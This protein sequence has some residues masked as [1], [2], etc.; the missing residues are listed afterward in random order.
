MTLYNMV[1]NAWLEYEYHKKG[2]NTIIDSDIE[3]TINYP[4]YYKNVDSLHLVKAFKRITE[5]SVIELHV[6]RFKDYQWQCPP[7]SNKIPMFTYLPGHYIGYCHS[8]KDYWKRIT[9]TFDEREPSDTDTIRV[10]PIDKQAE[11]EKVA[12]NVARGRYN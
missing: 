12:R 10:T 7:G 2:N 9:R 4:T 6:L 8:G 5:T 1:E 3:V 11:I